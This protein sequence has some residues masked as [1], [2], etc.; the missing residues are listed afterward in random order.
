VSAIAQIVNAFSL[1]LLLCQGTAAL[2]LI[3]RLIRGANRRPP[4]QP[5]GFT[6]QIKGK[7][8]V[9]V[10]TLNETDRIDNCLKGLSSQGDEVREI[11]IVD[12]NS[13]D[14][15]QEKVKQVALED[16]RFHLITDDPLPKGW[17]GRPWALHT[18]FLNISVDSEWFLGIDA[19]TQPQKG[20]VASSIDA[21]DREDYDLISLAPQ[22]ILKYPGEWLL[23]PALLITLLYRFDSAGVNAQNPERVMANGQC[24][25]C[26]RS[27]LE[28]VGGYSSASSSFCD[29]VT[30]ARQIAAAGFKVGFLDGSKIFKVRM[31]EGAAE[32][33]REWGRSLDLKDASSP[34]QVWSDFWFLLNVQGLPL[35]LSFL[36][37]GCWLLGYGSISLLAAL[38][39][40]LFLLIIR[41]SL[42]LAIAPSYDREQQFSIASWLFWFSP[43]ADPLAV[44]RILISSWQKPKQWRGRVYE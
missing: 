20:L 42:L 36:L 29:D 21:A 19:D 15:T 13:Q 40:N 23:Q 33:W 16:S 8:S 34:S 37:F 28:K 24:F 41:F 31:Y 10:P 39:L 9:V 30:L 27:V 12:S 32:T 25:L 11:I 2:I 44:L 22:F 5:K 1:V 7:V 26:R 14:G 3:S 6:P 35:I 17:I 4:L 38:S 43:F 18:G